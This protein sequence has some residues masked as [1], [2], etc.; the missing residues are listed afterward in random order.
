MSYGAVVGD[1][2]GAF[3]ADISGVSLGY[4][5]PPGAEAFRLRKVLTWLYPLI[6]LK[7]ILN[8]VES[9]DDKFTDSGLIIVYGRFLMRQFLI[10][11]REFHLN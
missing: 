1:D 11:E 3:V 5:L 4:K 9:Q 6:A 10:G 7:L 8:A 2:H